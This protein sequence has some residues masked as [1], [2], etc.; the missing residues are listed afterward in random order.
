MFTVFMGSLRIGLS[1]FSLATCRVFRQLQRDFGNG[2][3]PL[4][5]PDS[6]SPDEQL[7]I[8]RIPP[9]PREQCS[10]ADIL[11]ISRHDGSAL[12]VTLGLLDRNLSLECR[13][14]MYPP[15]QLPVV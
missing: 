8:G 5:P 9:S 4:G 11:K 6:S 13:P 14:R 10:S 15:A 12:S 2:C 3:V 7:S 1:L